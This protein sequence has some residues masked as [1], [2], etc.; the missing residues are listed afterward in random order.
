MDVELPWCWDR[1]LHRGRGIPE[2]LNGVAETW[3]ERIGKGKRRR[4]PFP[5]L[6]PSILTA[7]LHIG[8]KGMS[9]LMLYLENRAQRG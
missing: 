6:S 4:V 7:V 2:K 3:V 8:K 5:T 9:V 1:R